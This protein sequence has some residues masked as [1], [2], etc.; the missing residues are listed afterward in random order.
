MF[1]HMSIHKPHPHATDDLAASMQRF[2]DGV[3]TSSASRTTR[4]RRT[5]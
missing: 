4:S 3:R 2:G 5:F 1:L